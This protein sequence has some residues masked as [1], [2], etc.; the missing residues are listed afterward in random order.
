MLQTIENLNGKNVYH[1]PNGVAIN[2]VFGENFIYTKGNVDIH[3]AVNGKNN[4]GYSYE[5]NLREELP[6]SVKTNVELLGGRITKGAIRYGKCFVPH[7]SAL[8]KLKDYMALAEI[9]SSS[10]ENSK[11]NRIFVNY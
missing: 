11:N 4:G 1:Y 5:Q 2:Y 9:I 3:I 7:N 10:L 6:Q 8:S